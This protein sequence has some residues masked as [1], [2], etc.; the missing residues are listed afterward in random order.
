MRKLVVTQ[1]SSNFRAAT[2]IVMA[3]IPT[4]SAG[5][6]LIRNVMAGVNASDINFSAGAYLPG[7]SPPFDAG[8]EA[9]GVVEAAGEGVESVR[10]GQPVAVMSF[11]AFAEFQLVPAKHLVPI[12]ALDARYL[13]LL[14]SGLTASVALSEVGQMRSGET[15]LVTAAGGGTGQFAVQLAHRAGALGGRARRD[16]AQP[17]ALCT[18]RCAGNHVIGTCSSDEKARGR[19]G[20]GSRWRPSNPP[21]PAPP[22]AAFLRDLGCDRVVNYKR[23]NLFEVLRREYPSGCV[24]G[25]VGGAASAVS[26]ALAG[27]R[28]AG[29]EWAQR[30]RRGWEA[31][32]IP[33]PRPRRAGWT[34]STSA[35]GGR[36]SRQR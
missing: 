27:R 34:S 16:G 5:Q 7:V 21:R 35:W 29:R 18:G 31:V 33:D 28:R 13:P 22:Q 3:P 17:T 11:G 19:E 20:G 9:L 10:A 6:V 25:W 4:A 12:P 1:L 24:W 2:K 23:E 14:V 15:V 26:W 32:R 30:K 8:F 36:C